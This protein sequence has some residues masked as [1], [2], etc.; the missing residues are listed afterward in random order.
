MDSSRPIDFNKRSEN[1]FYS[2]LANNLELD[3]R[4]HFFFEYFDQPKETRMS[5][6]GLQA[7]EIWIQPNRQPAEGTLGKSDFFVFV[8]C[9]A[10][11]AYM[12]LGWHSDSSNSTLFECSIF[13]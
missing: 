9:L 10:L 5:D 2:L 1:D 3:R 12:P 4:F 13:F 7:R 11:F 6:L 8:A